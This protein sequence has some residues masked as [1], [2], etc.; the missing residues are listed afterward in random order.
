MWAPLAAVS[1][2]TSTYRWGS[3][4]DHSCGRPLVLSAMSKEIC[5]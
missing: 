5:N 1:E 4:A 3:S 2:M